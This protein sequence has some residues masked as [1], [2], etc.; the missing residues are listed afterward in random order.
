[1]DSVTAE[2]LFTFDYMTLVGGFAAFACKWT[3][4]PGLFYFEGLHGR[5]DYSQ[6]SSCKFIASDL[7]AGKLFN[8]YVI[9]MGK[10]IS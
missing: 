10:Q 1:L 5:Q 9:L 7:Y 3:S 4:N 2:E 8:L 6:A